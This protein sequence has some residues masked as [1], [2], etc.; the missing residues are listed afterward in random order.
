V[1]IGP[2]DLMDGSAITAGRDDYLA[3]LEQAGYSD[4]E[5]AGEKG[6]AISILRNGDEAYPVMSRRDRGGDAQ[7][8]AFQLYLSNR[9][10]GKPFMAALVRAMQRGVEVRVLIDC[11]GGGYFTSATYHQL[12]SARVAGC[13]IHAF[14]AARAHA[15]LNLRSH[16]KILA[17]T[18]VS[19]SREG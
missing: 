1:G 5:S 15:F 13:A 4:H 6:N 14:H 11:I 3:Q 7:R 10:R 19:L 17:S 12:R 2:T 16:K 18:A 9:R 8:G